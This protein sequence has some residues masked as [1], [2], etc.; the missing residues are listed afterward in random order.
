MILFH[1]PFTMTI[2]ASSKAGKTTFTCKFLKENKTLIDNPPVLIFYYYVHY[3][4]CFDEI[5]H[6][7]NFKQGLPTVSD[8]LPFKENILVVFDDFMGSKGAE[9]ILQDISTKL[10][11]HKNISIIW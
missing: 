3:N 11:H 6:F 8:L 5:K 7:V 2:S 10:G 9:Q 1:S 4:Q